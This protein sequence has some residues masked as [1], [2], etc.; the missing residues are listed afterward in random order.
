VAV[1][2]ALAVKKCTHLKEKS[3]V[4]SDDT[5]IPIR[6]EASENSLMFTSEKVNTT[7]D[8]GE[9]AITFSVIGK[10][11]SIRRSRVNKLKARYSEAG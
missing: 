1:D 3:R 6:P 11:V 2:G 4:Q 7:T 5:N 8:Q 9:G 10:T